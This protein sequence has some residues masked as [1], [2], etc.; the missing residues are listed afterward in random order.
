LKKEKKKI[1]HVERRGK[2]EKNMGP[3]KDGI[4]WGTWGGKKK[5]PKRGVLADGKKKNEK[6][7]RKQRTKTN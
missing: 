2:T 4:P 3:M 1:D 7:P 5:R 6:I